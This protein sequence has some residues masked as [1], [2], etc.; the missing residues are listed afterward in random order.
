[1]TRK[2]F[3][4]AAVTAA[5]VLG[6]M[7]TGP[8]AWAYEPGPTTVFSTDGSTCN[9]QPCVLYPK[10]AQLPSGRVLAAFEDSEGPV[11]GQTMPI[12]KS[13]DNGD[14]WQKL[15]DL[16]PP[17][18]LSS[19][20]QYAD[21]T[22]NWTNPYFYVLPE[23]L[24]DL[25]AGTTVLATVVSSSVSGS[26][27]RP[28]NAI[29]LY[30]TTDEG[31]TWRVLTTIA[32][33]AD[34]DTDALWE[35]F[36]MMYQGR[37]VAY[38]SDDN[39]YSS[40]DPTTGIPTLDPDNDNASGT[41]DPNRQVLLHKTWDGAGAWSEPVIDVAGTTDDVGGGRLEIGGG[42]PGMTTV[43]PTTDG[44]W[45]L[46][47]EYWGGGE[48]T[49]YKI[50][51]DPLKFFAAGGN[52]GTGVGSLP[53]ASGSGYLSGGGSP[54]LVRRPDGA[55]MFD[56]RD[57]DDVWINESGSSTGQWKQYHTSVSRGYSRNLQ[58]LSTTG[59]V[60][61]MSAPWGVGPVT[62]GVTDFGSSQG[63]Y[64]AFVNRASG[65]VLAPKNG[66]TQDAQFN[67]WTPDITTVSRD[68]A[69][70][71]QWWHQFDKG[72]PKTLLNKSGGRALGIWGGGAAAG[73]A[74]A[75]WVD[76]NGA[77]KKWQLVDSG[78]GYVRLIP[79]GNSGVALTAAA[80]G[81][82][83]LRATDATSQAQQ[84][85]VVLDPASVPA[86]VPDAPTG[87]TGTAGDGTATLQWTAPADGGS[88][89]TG[90]VV[91]QFD[92]KGW[93]TVAEPTG[94]TTVISGLTNG[95]AYRFRIA[96]KNA[97][98]TGPATS[99]VSV[100]PVAPTTPVP[101]QTPAPS[102]SASSTPSAAPAG[103][104]T[105]PAAPMSSSSSPSLPRSLAVTGAETPLLALLL[106][107]AAAVGGGLLMVTRRRR[108][109]RG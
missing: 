76:D 94:T 73:N 4:L 89:V 33:S 78:D 67:G 47:F 13:D 72:G 106:A 69:N 93:K 105:T 87:V 52:V 20:P 70:K 32:T 14:S 24:G 90:Y 65:K 100:T 39:D 86:A 6:T 3:T 81:S 46:T 19:D 41:V 60:L 79:N 43:A 29:V 17:A 101:T 31:Q 64:Y 2:R 38:Y 54:V 107:A 9:K 96:A 15:T 84:W 25:P 10:T 66:F 30:T 37:L 40:Y 21:W 45:L 58:Y 27:A 35:P 68:D 108:S 104:S 92:G 1:M 7:L 97:T 102:S 71:G 42:N 103:A 34:A 26:N 98:G 16:Q 44:K 53:L 28:A 99:D 88:A 12:Y 55:I 56:S 50:A 77:D 22:S 51:D 5:T 62:A 18:E 36:L 11:A 74:A 91:E 57:G 8:V 23:A 63:A 59:Q 95:T 49:R 83:A 61:I 82:V 48:N 75:S 85:Q 80:D 109:A